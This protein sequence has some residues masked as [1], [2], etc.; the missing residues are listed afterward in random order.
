M[1]A[2]ASSYSKSGNQSA[3]EVRNLANLGETASTSRVLNLSQIFASSGRSEGYAGN[4]F[5]RNSQLNKALLIK[6]TLR[7]GER[8]LFSHPRRT[9]TK[10]ILPFDASDLRL[11][12]RSIFVNQSGFVNFTRSYFSDDNPANNP[13]LQILQHLDAIPSLDP[14]LVREHLAR[15]GFRPDPCYLK[16]SP[17]DLSDMIG[18]ANAEIERLVMTAFGAGMEAAAM[19][20]TAKILAN[21]LDSDLD[22]LKQTFRMSDT[23]FGEG[24][25]SWRGFLYFKWRQ[26]LLQ[27][28]IRQVVDG[29]QNYRTIGPAEAGTRD[30][31]AEARPRLAKKIIAAIITTYKTLKVYDEAYQALT[32]GADPAPFRKFLLDGPKMFF[33]LGESIGILSHIGSFWDYRMG[34]RM[35][36]MRLT[37]QEFADIIVDF[38]DSLLSVEPA[39]V[40]TLPTPATLL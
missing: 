18:F 4:P 9:A 10:I 37:P 40:P 34:K 30:Y 11:G 14:F 1:N 19:K 20:L 32:Q 22:P 6:H 17:R 5:F 35:A 8:E 39:T 15:F 24:M 33:E 38:E 28:D 2:L 27:E 31:L 26:T 25:F 16:I 13:D 29:L 7:P 36:H 12:G 21:N 23:D 3:R